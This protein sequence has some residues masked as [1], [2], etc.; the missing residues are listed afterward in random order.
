[1]AFLARIIERRVSLFFA[2]SSLVVTGRRFRRR[3][4][5]RRNYSLPICIITTSKFHE[6]SSRSYGD[7]TIR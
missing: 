2:I 7:R 5:R 6:A 4:R 3:F 1:M